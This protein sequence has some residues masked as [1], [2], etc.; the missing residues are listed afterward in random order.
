MMAYPDCQPRATPMASTSWVGGIGNDD[1]E[2]E[3]KKVSR[4]GKRGEEK[5]QWDHIICT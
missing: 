3:A 5:G 2:K 1:E 4:R